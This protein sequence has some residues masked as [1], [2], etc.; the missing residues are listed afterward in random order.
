MNDLIRN[1]IFASK[2]AE[3]SNNNDVSGILLEAS[4]NLQ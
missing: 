3:I 2:M 4:E 1:L